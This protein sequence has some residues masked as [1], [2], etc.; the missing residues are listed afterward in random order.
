MISRRDGPGDASTYNA[1]FDPVSADNIQVARECNS[2]WDR[3]GLV[4]DQSD[5]MDPFE[6]VL[7]RCCSG[8]RRQGI[9]LN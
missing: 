9:P 7:G 5:T 6:G 2:Y 3:E 4:G 1:D 8:P